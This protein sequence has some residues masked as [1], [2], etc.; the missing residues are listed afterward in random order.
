MKIN[1]YTH[2]FKF[3]HGKEPR[4]RGWWAFD[5]AG[6]TVYTK[7]SMTYADAKKMAIGIA[8]EKG[9]TSIYVLP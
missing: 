3:S 9:K 4:G 6:E 7:R 2:K 8:K 5:I 1:V